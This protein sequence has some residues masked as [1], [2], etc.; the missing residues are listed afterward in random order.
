[1]IQTNNFL[2]QIIKCNEGRGYHKSSLERHLKRYHQE[3][4]P[5]I[6]THLAPKED[7]KSQL[8]VWNA[9]FIA[10]GNLPKDALESEAFRKWIQR[11][12]QTFNAPKM[13]ED[14][15]MSARTI[16]RQM[17]DATAE[18]LELI[19]SKGS[20]LAKEGKIALQSDHV[21]LTKATGE[22]VNSFLAIIVTIR[23]SKEEMVPFPLCFEPTTAKTFSA[24]RNDLRRHLQVSYLFV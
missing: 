9:E 17:R 24:F 1:M 2:F 4:Q 10:E 6:L 15:P 18:T 19:K 12:G 14:V 7:T 23:N 13:T 11:L 20:F 16:G 3:N 22:K 5:S 8:K 21:T